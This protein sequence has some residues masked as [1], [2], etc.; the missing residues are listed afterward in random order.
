MESHDFVAYGLPLIEEDDIAGVL[1]S[2][3]SGWLTRGPKTL[4]FEKTF[5]SYVGAKHA[6]AV[7]S[8][9]SGLHLTLSCLDLGPGD[10]VITTPLTFVATVN[11]IIHTGAKPVLVDIDPYT[12]N[13]DGRKIEEAI[14]SHTKA[15]V[16]V[17]IAG[18]PCDMDAVMDLAGRHRIKVIEDAAHAIYTQY[19]G[20]MVGSIGDATVFS[21]YATKNLVTG[22]GGM[23]TT[24]DD[25]LAE[26][27]RLWSSH[28]LSHGA[29]NRYTDQGSWFYEVLVPG[30]KYNMTDIQAALGLSQL[31]KLN[32]MQA[33]REEIARYYNEAFAGC[34]AIELPIDSPDVRHA[35][36]L[37]IV[38]L[39]LA[40][41]SVDRNAF[42]DRLKEKGVGSSVHFIPVHYHPYHRDYFAG[43]SY[44]VTEEIFERIVSLPLYPKMS[45]EDVAKVI[46]AVM[47][48]LN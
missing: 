46:Q 33:R 31:K 42:I 39:N 38:K 25:D 10:E 7:N 41:I 35:W 26:R 43:A 24:N 18:Y 30:Y 4:E 14:T 9:T 28:G 3:R 45:D 23:V 34:P 8:C 29:W 13:I 12:M 15:L 11:T 48:I 5:A 2:F 44:P 20:R 1:D 37:Y 32:K 22:E 40:E 16:P 27:L 36:H 21:F 6:V 17:H 19:Q 47:E